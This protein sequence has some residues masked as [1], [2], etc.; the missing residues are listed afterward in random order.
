MDKNRAKQ[1]FDSPN[2]I[3]VTYEGKPVYIQHVNEDHTARV[4]PLDHPD[5]EQNVPVSSLVEQGR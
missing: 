1:I 5:K 3:K 2:M 4:Y